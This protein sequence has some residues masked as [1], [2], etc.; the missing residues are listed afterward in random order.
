M[1]PRAKTV[2]ERALRENCD[3]MLA[4]CTPKQVAFFHVIQDKAPWKGWANCPMER[5]Q[6]PMMHRPLAEA[7]DLLCRTVDENARAQS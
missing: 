7:H 5:G 1:E 3:R 4:Q 2:M 6:V